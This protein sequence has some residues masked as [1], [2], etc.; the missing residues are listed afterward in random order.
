MRNELPPGPS[1]PA[2][3]QS[4][5]WWARPVPFLERC[6]ARYGKRFTVRLLGTPPFVNLSDP[7]EIKE[8]FMAPPDVLH[9]GEGA[10]V[11]EPVVGT[12]SLIL[13][14]EDVHLQQRRLM[15]PAFHGERMKRLTGV[16]T[17]VIEREVESWP[18]GELKLHPRMQ[19]LTLEIILR[20]VFGLDAGER[21][22]AL[23][24]RV[25]RILEFGTN[26]GSLL[27]ML[28]RDFWPMRTWSNFL[29]LRDEA[30]ALIYDLIAERRA[31]GGDRDDVLAM[32]LTARHE[33]GS[34][35]S[36]KELRDELMTLLV[37]G[38]ETTAS[39]LAWTFE[40]VVR[41]PRVLRRLTEAVDA[42]EDEYVDATVNESLRSRP[43]LPIAEPRL[44][45]QDVEI[46]GWRYPAGCALA[47]NVYLVHHDPAI[48]EEPYAFRP[49]R[50]L[51]QQPGTYTWIPFGGGR[52]RC[53]GA[54]F[55][56]LE[57]RL[58]LKAVLSRYELEP[59]EAGME[60]TRRRAITYTPSRGASTIVR[61]RTPASAPAEPDPVLV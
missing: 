57:M 10:Q 2:T 54:S 6:R 44:V 55:A 26:P 20:A 51:D 18:R 50:F 22:D 39:Q 61:D 37:A 42:D 27:P 40:R 9:P 58:V 5:A 46:G 14:D 11:L 43:V 3:V 33:D 31:A 13:L 15:L 52:R 29:A 60:T 38:H 24:T 34:P 7:A 53:I 35:M 1:W 23:R 47:I 25:T 49:E 30:D 45:K 12:Y 17:E 48:Y 8:A 56:Q 28:R 4:V 32:L 19:E 59:T 41:D 21:L 36:P 16:M